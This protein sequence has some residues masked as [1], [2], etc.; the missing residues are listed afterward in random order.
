[1]SDPA[2]LR[3]RK[4]R[5]TREAI[6]G[7]AAVLFAERGFDAVTVEEVAR[8]A[9]VS[10]QTIFNYFRSKEEM[11]F[12]RDAQVEAALL[13]ALRDREP[14]TSLVD[15]FRAHTCA[16]WE[17]LET[18]GALHH[19]FWWIVES[20]PALRDYAE[21]VFGRH[22]RSVALM[23]ASEQRVPEDDPGCHALARMLC[24][25]NVAVLTCG[26]SRIARGQNVGEVAGEMVVEA[27]RAYGLLERG[28][29]DRQGPA[30]R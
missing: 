26:L 17:R 30:S 16:F 28:L 23:L 20:S 11:L 6:A 10:R 18:D 25:V 1:V 4:K 9:D 7:A 21:S 22:A 13:A 27:G 15:V 14:G 2:G 19:D 3:E 8:A 24:G 5:Q 12:D 29:D